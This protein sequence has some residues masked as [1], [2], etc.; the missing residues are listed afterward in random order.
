MRS[1]TVVDVH[2][3]NSMV[4]CKYGTVSFPSASIFP[5]FMLGVWIREGGVLAIHLL[6]NF[7]VLV[8]AAHWVQSAGVC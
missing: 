4:L 3:V 7:G 2:A 8:M 1:L 6:L 5:D